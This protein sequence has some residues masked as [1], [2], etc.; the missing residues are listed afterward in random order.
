MN[1]RRRKRESIIYSSMSIVFL[2]L[3]FLFFLFHNGEYDYSST[4]KFLALILSGGTIGT[5][6]RYIRF[7]VSGTVPRFGKKS[8]TFLYRKDIQIGS[9]VLLLWI[10]LFSANRRLGIFHDKNWMLFTAIVFAIWLLAYLIACVIIT[11]RFSDT[12]K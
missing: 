6:I 9:Y 12:D 4:I 3:L 8:M 2:V 5:C 1:P 10:A 7:S 11:Q